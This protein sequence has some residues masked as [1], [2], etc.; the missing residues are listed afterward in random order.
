VIHP[1]DR[2]AG[3]AVAHGPKRLKFFA[4]GWGDAA[5]LVPPD[6][7]IVAAEPITPTFI[8]DGAADE[9]HL[10]HGIYRSVVEGLPLRSQHGSVISIE[11][12]SGAGR[13]VVLMAAWN[14]HDPKIRVALARMLAE[15][16]VRSLIPENPFYGSRHPDPT[17]QQPIRTVAD[18]MSMG[19]SAVVEARGLLAGLRD[20]DTTLG[21]SGYS[22]GANVAA[23]VSATLD[24]PIATAPLAASHSPGPVFLDGVLRHG[25]AWEALGGR[26]AEPR[27]REILNSASVLRVPAAP[28][29][30][31]AVVVGARSDGYIPRKATTDLVDHW[32]GSDLRIHAGGHATMIWY[33]KRQLVNA[34]EDSFDRLEGDGQP[35]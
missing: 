2:A 11:P 20:A 4:D 12:E 32:P 7:S 30:K 10:S 27:L 6:L 9:V 13:T 18:F 31:H 34:I 5:A 23:I 1:I 17:D 26:E 24:F 16:G 15:R 3:L 8:V 35:A 25:I 19:G 22:M 29:T 21:V 14:E 28:H 33:R